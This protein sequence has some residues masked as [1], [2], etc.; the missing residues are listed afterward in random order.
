MIRN[1]SGRKHQ[2]ISTINILL[3]TKEGKVLQDTVV[4]TTIVNFAEI[5]EETI[6][7][8][9]KTKSGWGKAGAYGI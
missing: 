3:K 9:S 8:Y 1:F 5:P 7:A 4:E 6:V 2:V